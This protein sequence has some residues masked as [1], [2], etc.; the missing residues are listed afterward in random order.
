MQLPLLDFATLTRNMAAAVQGTCRQLVDLT[1]GSVLR[2]LLEANAS[3]ALWMQWLIMQV[4]AT[5]R[6]ATS[7]GADLDS[8]V[9]D[10]SLSR[11][12]AIPAIGNVTFARFTSGYP[13]FIPAGTLVRTADGSGSFAVLADPTNACWVSTTSGYSVPAAATSI[14]LPVQAVMAGASG[15]VQAGTISLLASPLPGIDTVSNSFSLGGGLD[16]ETDAALRLRFQNYLNSRARATGTAIGYAITA[17]QQGLSY[18]ISENMD[19]NG[20]PLPGNFVVTVDDGSGAPPASL[21]ATVATAVEAVRPLTS[22]YAVRPPLLVP[23]TISLTLTV[24]QASQRPQAL[25]AVS[26]AVSI[27]VNTLPIGGILPISRL[28]QI[29]YDAHPAVANVSQVSINGQGGDLLPPTAGVVKA[30][31]VSVN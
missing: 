10:F 20:N 13:A 28:S 17:I 24:S 27:W 31:S 30:A 22:T 26:N 12:P 4:L 1:V 7:A 14:T 11:L 21:L 3:V 23:A 5:T 9:A 6:A 2:A 15:N 25:S 29:A 18:T 16:A 19:L 8:W